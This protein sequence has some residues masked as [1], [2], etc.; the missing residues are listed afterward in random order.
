MAYVSDESG[1]YEVYV[2][3]FPGRGGKTLVSTNGGTEPAWSPDGTELLYRN[4]NRMMVSTMK[5]PSPGKPEIL[6]QGS[7]VASDPNWNS[8][9]NY[10][11]S[12]DGR[13]FVMVRQTASSNQ[14]NVVLN[15]FGVIEDRVKA[16]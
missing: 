4:G 9:R 5:S 7:F 2:Q 6:F 15:F 12:P 3:D 8:L 14:L 10:D 1:R 16:R 13:R 11:I